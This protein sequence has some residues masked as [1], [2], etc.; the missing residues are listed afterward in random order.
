MQG[1]GADGRA[2]QF[3]EGEQ[4]EPREGELPHTD[5]LLHVGQP[6]ACTANTLQRRRER[7]RVHVLGILKR[8]PALNWKLK[9]H[10]CFVG[11]KYSI[12]SLKNQFFQPEQTK[13]TL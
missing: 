2:I 4:L 8:K 6:E 12:G 7:V 11:I 13:S 1:V 9:F 10:E 3:R 5:I